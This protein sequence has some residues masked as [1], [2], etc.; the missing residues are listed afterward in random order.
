[1]MFF[2]SDYHLGHANIIKYCNR[3]F[4]DVKDMDEHIISAHNEKVS[5]ND[6]VYFLGD[7]SFKDSIEYYRNK[8]NGKIHLIMGNHDHRHLCKN[9]F[10]SIRDMAVLN[11]ENTQI[12]LCHYAMRVW[13]NSHRN[14]IHLYGHSHGRVEGLGKSMDVGIDANNYAGPHSL[15]EIMEIMKTKP[16]NWDKL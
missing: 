3:P 8:L 1:M 9:C 5:R 12:I 13:H 10:E 14:T 11:V 6:T 2:T 15:D 16:D 7:F 4:S